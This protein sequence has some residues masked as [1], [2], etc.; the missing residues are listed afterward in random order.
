VSL[1][2]SKLESLPLYHTKN[3]KIKP[4]DKLA[5]ILMEK[6]ERK[7]TNHD[8]DK[9]TSRALRGVPEIIQELN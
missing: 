7:L 5:L 3:F 2:I 1:N 6:R 8:T 4:C 9:M